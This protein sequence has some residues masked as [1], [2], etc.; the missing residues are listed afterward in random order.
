LTRTGSAPSSGA[1]PELASPQGAGFRLRRKLSLAI[2]PF[3]AACTAL[4]EHPRLAELWPEYLIRQHQIIRATVPLTEVAAQRARAL[5]DADPIAN[6]LAAYL[7]EHIGEE[8]GHD[9]DLLGDLQALGLE[10]EDVLARMPS[11]TVASLVG[12]QYYWT[13][14]YHPIAF[15]GFVALMEGF[16]PTPALIEALMTRTGHPVEAFRT[17]AEHG[18]LDPGHRE[19]LDQTLDSLPLTPEHEVVMG[20]SAT[21]TA[22]LAAEVVEEVLEHRPQEA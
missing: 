8:L 16:P 21:S 17:F 4:V 7:D 3:G 12:S 19:R 18:E 6:G 1:E 14:H 5:T 22:G 2:G 10:R 9:E 15:L 13:L 11:P 20:V